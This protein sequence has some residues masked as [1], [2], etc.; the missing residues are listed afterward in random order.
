MTKS[1][2]PRPTAPS[3]AI[4]DER[5]PTRRKGDQGCG[6]PDGSE[7]VIGCTGAIC[8]NAPG[9]PPYTSPWKTL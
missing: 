8:A 4:Q 7:R 6:T 5:E 1:T 2:S 3:P 9:L